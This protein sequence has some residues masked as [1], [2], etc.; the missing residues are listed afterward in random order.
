MSAWSPHNCQLR[1]F[2]VLFIQDGV[3]DHGGTEV[4]H[5][6]INR[7]QNRWV[8]GS[9]WML[10]SCSNTYYQL[11][12]V[13][14]HILPKQKVFIR[15]FLDMSEFSWSSPECKSVSQNLIFH[16][17]AASVSVLQLQNK[18][19]CR[20]HCQKSSSECWNCSEIIQRGMKR[21]NIWLEFTKGK[22][23]GAKCYGILQWLL[24]WYVLVF[25]VRVV[26][27]AF[28]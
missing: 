3:G 15:L 11:I 5:R 19:S 10:G 12:E 25:I 22:S 21:R 16:I 8:A 2:V 23:T 4:G 6:M 9:K 14:G 13:T 7:H 26:H 17:S 18:Q 20:I 24:K 28:T 27:P 1:Q